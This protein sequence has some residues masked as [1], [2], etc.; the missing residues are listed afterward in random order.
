[1]RD[2]GSGA[3]GTGNASEERVGIEAQILEGRRT[4]A[5]SAS[6]LWI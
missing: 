6:S 3:A 2:P 5:I 4:A 1:M